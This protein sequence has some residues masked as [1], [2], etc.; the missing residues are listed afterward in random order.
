MPK[1]H[2]AVLAALVALLGGQ[3]R[4]A[5][6]PWRAR[7]AAMLAP[8]ADRRAG[9]RK[10]ARA[11]AV[12]LASPWLELPYLVAELAT[13]DDQRAALSAW[14]AAGVRRAASPSD[15]ARGDLGAATAMLLVGMWQIATGSRATAA[16]V[17][18]VQAQVAAA[19][20]APKVRH[21]PAED[22]QRCWELCVGLEAVFTG[23]HDAGRGPDDVASVRNAAHAV[24]AGLLRI[25]GDALGLG[26]GG[27][28]RDAAAEQAG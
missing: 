10:P 18:A 4:L 9:R 15:P 12:C 27:F 21:M 3:D 26:E 25:P 14:C 19:L 8:N 1:P 6:A 11:V 5:D 23:L 28:H 20:D 22:L 17:A 13:G 2:P 24:L 7:L 16:Q